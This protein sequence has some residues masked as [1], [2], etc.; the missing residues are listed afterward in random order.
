MPRKAEAQ[1]D[2]LLRAIGQPDFKQRLALAASGAG[3]VVFDH[4]DEASHAW[5]SA[6]VLKHLMGSGKRRFWLVCEG[7]RQRERLA[8]ELELW[9][10]DAADLPEPPVELEGGQLADPETAAQRLEVLDMAAQREACVI[11]CGPEAFEHPAPSPAELAGSRISI[12]QGSDADPLDLAAKLS[13][14]GYDRVTTVQ[15]RGQFAVRGGIL[16]VFPW[17]GG[18]PLRIEF[19]DTEVESLR[20]FDVDSQSSTGKLDSAELLLAEPEL[21]ATVADYLRPDDTRIAYEEAELEADVRITSGASNS[22]GEE[23]FSTACFGSPLG[24][25]EAGDFVLEQSR[26]QRFFSQLDEWRA[27]DW[28]I[29]MVFSNKGEED[30]FI[31]LAGQDSIADLIRLR[32]ELVQG[33]TVPAARMA[34]LSSSELFGRYRTPGTLKRSR[35]DGHRVLTARA[36]LDDIAEGDLVVHYEYGIGRFRGIAPGESGEEISIEYREGGL[37]SVPIDQAHLVAKYVGLGGKTPELNKLGGATWKNIR[38]SAEKSILDYAAQ[39]LR[40]QAER[41]AEP[42]IPHPPD[43]RWMWEFENSFHFTETPDQ[44]RAIEQSKRDMES[45]K[46]MDRLICGDVGFGKTEVAIRA[47]FKAA[48]GGMQ[49]AVLVPTTVLAEQH[50]RTFRERMSD[51]PIRVELLNRFRTPAQIRETIQ[52]LADG[53]VDI[54]IG[55]HRLISGDVHF[56]NLALAV[57]DEEQRFGVKHKE[58][59]KE[60]FRSIDVMTLSATPIPRTLYM[61]LMGARD[62][63]TIDTPPPNRVPVHTSVVQYDE[64]I[65]REAIQREMKRGGQ[66]FF[67]HNR[68]KSIEMMRKKLEELVPEA[69]I[70][71]GHGQME[72][73]DLEVVMRKFVHG[74]ADILLATTIIETGIDIPN[75]NTILIDR[76]DRFGLAD[77]Y[78]LR[79][80]VGR[81]GEK[82]YAILLLPR[83]FITAGDARKRIHAI[84]QYTALGSGFKIAMRDLEIRGAGNLL[85]TKQSGHIAAVGFDL[86]CQLL[87]QSVDRLQG[88]TPKAR[89]EASF[90][91][92]FVAFSEA[93]FARGS[94]D[95]ELLP[96]FLPNAWLGE[97]QLRVSA[98]RELAETMVEKDLDQMERRWRDR[99]GRLPEAAENLIVIGRIRLAAAGKGVSSV[100]IKGQRLMLQRGGDYIMLEGRRFPRLVSVEPRDKVIEALE[101]LRS[102]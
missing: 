56:K 79:G 5:L 99:F 60:L 16:D 15:G 54:V 18:R 74:E 73:D 1:D 36:S 52:G 59:F 21:E 69:R 28:K 66:V 30:R 83:D 95:G 12:R 89:V 50:W 82:A 102:L 44:R 33:F 96:A 97:T 72:K 58:K 10:I 37:L 77:L 101:M 70:L 7:P 6:V 26:R 63:S 61:A 34:V 24:S 76:A 81:A 71:V 43:S 8:A 75:A 45:A 65:I 41:Q 46:P 29:G 85:G 22:V 78:Q 14:H 2:W 35:Q 68:V 9:G 91:S 23:D 51:Y 55:T 32:G 93:E 67:L 80:R 3:G 17:Q 100:E 39:L 86:Y 40:V 98:Y 57:V 48:T 47:A 94:G 64:R 92:D 27:Q 19:F 53:S 20:E 88:R 49:V 84:K 31:E 87:R 90:R 38:K 62:M 13:T 11:L 4:A 42:G 25:F